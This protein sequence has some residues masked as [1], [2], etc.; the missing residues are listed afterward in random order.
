M[1]IAYLHDFSYVQELKWKLSVM[2]Q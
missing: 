2:Y 1:S